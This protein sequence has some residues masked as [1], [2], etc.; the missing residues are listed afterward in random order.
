LLIKVEK[1]IQKR[2]GFPTLLENDLRKVG[3]I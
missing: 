1:G 3:N 2:G